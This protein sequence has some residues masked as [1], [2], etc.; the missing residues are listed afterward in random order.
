MDPLHILKRIRYRYLKKYLSLNLKFVNEH[1][2]LLN[3]DVLKKQLGSIDENVFN[4]STMNKMRDVLALK[5]FS[6]IAINLQI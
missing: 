5:M 3:S 2:I 6:K 1:S 4:D